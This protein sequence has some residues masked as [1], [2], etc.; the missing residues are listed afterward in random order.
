MSLGRIGVIGGGASGTALAQVAAADGADVLLWALESTL[1]LS[2]PNR[3]EAVLCNTIM[4]PTAATTLASC[5]ASRMG[6][7]TSR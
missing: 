3:S 7:N 2:E 1:R 5:G 4:M 6:R